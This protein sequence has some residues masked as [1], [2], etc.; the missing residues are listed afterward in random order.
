MARSTGSKRALPTTL[1]ALIVVSAAQAQKS[2]DFSFY[3][4]TAQDCLYNAA[5][6]SQCEAGLVPSTNSCLCRNGGS[7]VTNT[8]ACLGRTSPGD[9]QTVFDTFKDACQ[10][11]HTPINFSEEFFMAAASP[12]TP[13]P[14]TPSSTSSSIPSTQPGDEEKKGLPTRSL[15]GIIAGAVVGSIILFVVVFL[16]FRRNKKDKKEAYRM[17]QDPSTPPNPERYMQQNPH[18]YTQPNPHVS[19]APSAGETSTSPYVS[20]PNTG[21]WPP[22]NHQLRRMP[23]PNSSDA[24]RVSG[25]NWESPDQLAMPSVGVPSQ[26]SQHHTAYRPHSLPPPAELDASRNPGRPVEVAGTP[27]HPTT[28]LFHK[29]S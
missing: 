4:K 15:A 28:S 22:P 10:T 21:G 14:S 2:I 20:P 23:S 6:P 5:A 9:L 12:A 13:T 7:F 1:V 11:S 24:S 26:P 27:V 29:M 17:H 16:I 3:P 25:F 18:P 8:A 19:L